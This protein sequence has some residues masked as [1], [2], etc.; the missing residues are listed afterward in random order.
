[1]GA[2]FIREVENGE[3]VIDVPDSV[4]VKNLN[5]LLEKAQ[6]IIPILVQYDT[7]LVTTLTEGHEVAG[8]VNDFFTCY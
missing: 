1:M 5:S 6:A 3:I 8:S 2:T 7:G 4:R